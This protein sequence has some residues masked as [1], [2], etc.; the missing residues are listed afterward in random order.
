ML[1]EISQPFADHETDSGRSNCRLISGKTFSTTTICESLEDV[2]SG[3]TT[4]FISTAELYSKQNK[5]QIRVWNFEYAHLLKVFHCDLWKGFPLIAIRDI[6]D[7][8]ICCFEQSL[9]SYYQTI[10]FIRERSKRIGSSVIL[11]AL[12]SCNWNYHDLIKWSGEKNGMENT[13]NSLTLK[14]IRI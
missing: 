2:C 1:G 7:R 11:W 3:C 10:M 8:M 13:L 14:K 12:S 6:S 4:G 5:Y 9:L